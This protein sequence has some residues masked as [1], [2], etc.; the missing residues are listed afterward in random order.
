MMVQLLGLHTSITGGPGSMPSQGTNPA[1]SG[2]KKENKNGPRVSHVLILPT[3]TSL[4][5]P[6]PFHSQSLKENITLR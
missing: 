5:E 3:S 1:N 4:F 6:F 2:K